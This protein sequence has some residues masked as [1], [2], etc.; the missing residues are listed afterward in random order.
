MKNIDVLQR[1]FQYVGRYKARMIFLLFIG[2]ISI[3]FEVAKP[4]PVKIVIDHVLTGNPLPPEVLAFTGNPFF[5]T[6][7]YEL[8]ITSVIIMIIIT[9]GSAFLAYFSMSF[10]VKLAQ[11]LVFDLS[12]DFFKK[13]QQLSLSFFNK[14]KTGDL[15]QRISGD[16]FVV[17]FLVAQIIIPL[18]TSIVALSLMFLIMSRIDLTLALIALAVIPLM[19]MLL[20]FFVK[21]MND[22]SMLQYKKLGDLS[23]F[24]QQSLSSMK[25]IQAFGRESFMNQKIEIFA[26]EYGKAFQRSTMVSTGFNQATAVITGLA[27][28]GLIGFGA[29]RGIE[30]NFS[31]GDLYLFIGYVGG[32][33]A[34]VTSLFT[35]IGTSVVIGS[36]GK[37]VFEIMDSTETVIEN[38]D[39]AELK[40]PIESICFDHVIF[41][42]E[43][44]EKRKRIILNEINFDVQPGKVVAIVG[45]TGAGKT[46]LISLL[47]RFFDPDEGRIMI[48]E[49]DIRN[50]R[51]KDIREQ[52]SIVLQDPFLFPISIRE[53]IAFGNPAASD[54]EIEAAA[55]DALAHEFISKLPDGYETILS[56]AG[57]T[58]SGGEKQRIALAR[59]FLKKAPI[60]ILDEPTSALDA[61]TESKIFNNLINQ[62][63]GRTVFLISH[64]LSTIKHADQIITLQDG[65]VVESGTHESLITKGKVYASLYKYHQIN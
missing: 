27:T 16:V 8:L 19:G 15:I 58:I 65:T 9:L 3:V 34:P 25:I 5:L 39:P 45:A 1:L 53:N 35:A 57:S 64:R 52:I 28:A 17:Y 26:Q 33:L 47:T 11:Q 46:S 41:S 23:A 30:G 20:A 60:W 38:P 61:L 40:L 42:Y 56:E 51:L 18:I 21:P 13:L 14:N 59:S 10:T 12:V 6:G 44:I 22:S 29:Y 2:L 62:S 31:A 50:Y 49:C 4:F 54:E 48:N 63:K 32:M 7:R 36:R 43:D 24:V 37:R 55:K